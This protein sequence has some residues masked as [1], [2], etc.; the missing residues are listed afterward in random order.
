MTLNVILGLKC[1]FIIGNVFCFNF[2]PIIVVVVI[3]AA[4]VIVVVD[5][6]AVQPHL[7]Q[8]I[9]RDDS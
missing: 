1:S 2:C 8:W 4:V 3:V 6:V 5:F 9:A 7:L